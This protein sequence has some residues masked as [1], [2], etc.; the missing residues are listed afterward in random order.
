MSDKRLTPRKMQ[1]L[2]AIVDAH[3]E[4]GDP[5]GSRYLSEMPELTCSSAT[6]RNEMAELE[7]MGYLVQPHTSA[8]R[9]PSE[10]GYRLYVDSLIR[11]YSATRGEIDSIREQLR[12]KLT[13][14]DEILSEASRIA[15]SFSDYTGIAFK[16]GARKVR[17]TR[18]N[19]V[20]LS[21]KDFLLV[22]SFGSD[23]V[24]SKTIHLPFTIN[25]DAVRRFTE[26]LNVY[27]VN[28]T[29]EEISMPIIVRLESIMGSYGAMVHPAVKAMQDAMIDD[30]Q[31]AKDY[32][33]LLCAQAQILA[34]LPLEDPAAYT[35]LVCK[36]MK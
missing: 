24:K 21:P 29:G 5:V 3:I 25:E 26:A 31:K 35:A 11:Q 8:G 22:M 18:F 2:K 19:S 28:L 10:M 30:T 7:S 23:T 15:S 20:Y 16:S 34:D 12:C 13:E 17:V 32:A 4:N 36:L 6:I 33:Q 27:L 9:I 14:M 1:I